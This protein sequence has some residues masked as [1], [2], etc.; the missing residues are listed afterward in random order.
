MGGVGILIY[1]IMNRKILC[2]GDSWAAGAELRR[3]EHPFVHWFA[4]HLNLPYHNY[5]KE[6]SSLAE[7][8]FTLLTTKNIS[9]DDIVIVVTPPDARSY[10]EEN[11][12]IVTATIYEDN[13][14]YTQRK[15]LKPEFQHRSI[16]WFEYHHL[17]FINCIQKTL[18]EIGCDYIMMH[19]YG[20]LPCDEKY[21]LHINRK[22][23]LSDRSLT[24]ILSDVDS[25][26]NNYPDEMYLSNTP[27]DPTKPPDELFAGKY[28][29]GK[30]NHPN[31]L[32]HKKIAELLHDILG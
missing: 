21:N 12:K 25:E 11:E 13:C 31:E 2:F 4:K 16:F 28:F 7:I 17:L 27:S 5:G 10:D 30:V 19:S 29:E 6:G 1:T 26:W 15:N 3:E 18:D 14:S 8:L 9:S 24:M 23:F 32:G 22:K 20:N